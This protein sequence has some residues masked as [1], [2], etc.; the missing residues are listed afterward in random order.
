MRNLKQIK[1][2]SDVL[3]K[4]GILT[5]EEDLV[6]M[7]SGL[8]VKRV[9][10]RKA[11]AV[12][13]IPILESGEV[14]L[15]RQWRYPTARALLELPAGI[16]E[17]G[18]DPIEAAKR[19]L[20]EEAG[21]YPGKLHEVMASYT[22][23]GYCDEMLSFYIATNLSP[24]KLPGDF[25][26]DIEVVIMSIEEALCNPDATAD[27]KTVAGLLYAKQYLAGNNLQAV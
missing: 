13:V 5:I 15:V 14:V 7:P 6:E 1:V 22:A 23:P 17:P 20:Q 16:L 2:E 9:I 27:L 21:F 11:S 18:E 3:L 4:T 24:S 8:Q 19:E 10:V 26:E 12:V 25:D